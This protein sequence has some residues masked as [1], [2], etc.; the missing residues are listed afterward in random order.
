MSA[1]IALVLRITLAL[2]LYT[3]LGWTIWSLGRDLQTSGRKDI[4]GKIPELNLAL[5]IDGRKISYESDG[6]LLTIGR[7]PNNI[8]PI[9]DPT[10]SA[11]HAQLEFHHS[12]WWLRDLDSRNGTLLNQQQVEEEVVV[13]SGDQLQVGNVLTCLSINHEE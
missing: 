11:Y 2:V 8:C 9:P 6:T 4:A 13:T 5:E 10:V 1:V 7:D 12:Q 3:F